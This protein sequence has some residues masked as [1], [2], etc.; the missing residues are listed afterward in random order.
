MGTMTALFEAGSVLVEQLVD[1]WQQLGH[2][3]V[4]D[5]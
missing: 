4:T 3:L 5:A 1:A 2:P